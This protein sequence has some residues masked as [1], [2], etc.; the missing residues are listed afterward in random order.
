[1]L[2][3]GTLC[4]LISIQGGLSLTF[5]ELSTSNITVRQMILDYHNNFRRN[6]K[7]SGKN[8][9]KM[10]WSEEAA[11]VASCWAKYCNFA[12]ASNP[13][14]RNIQGFDC[15]ENLFK[16][17]LLFSWK[18]VLETFFSQGKDF[19]Y[20]EG[21]TSEDLPTRYYTQAVWYKSFKVGCAVAEC[22]GEIPYYYYICN[23]CPSGNDKKYIATPYEAGNP[24]EACPESCDNGLCTN[25][26][27]YQDT[28]TFCNKAHCPCNKYFHKHCGATCFCDNNE[29]K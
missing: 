11:Q 26:C 14:S 9:L 17:T 12:R 21:P 3:I 2:L 25:Y 1:M 4:L 19:V 13:T 6:V 28:Y 22:H 7:P 10:E 18:D 15:G 8:M 27:R 5:S 20:G 24:C 16:S 29:I 23:Y